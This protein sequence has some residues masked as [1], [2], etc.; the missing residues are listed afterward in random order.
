LL[1]NKHITMLRHSDLGPEGFATNRKLKEMIDNRQITM[2]GNRHLKIYGHL[3]CGS[4]KRMKRSNR[5]F[6]P[7][8]QDALTQGYRPC[9]HCMREEYLKWKSG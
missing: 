8:E 9:G 7:H 5:V 6:F 1:T 4:G 3:S 2:A